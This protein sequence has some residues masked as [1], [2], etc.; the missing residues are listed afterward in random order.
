MAKKFFVIDDVLDTIVT[1]SAEMAIELSNMRDEIGQPLVVSYGFL[2]KTAHLLDSGLLFVAVDPVSQYAD[3]GVVKKVVDM[4]A[5][6]RWTHCPSARI[7][8]APAP[9]LLPQRISTQTVIL[10]RRNCFVRPKSHQIA[11]FG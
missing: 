11:R 2:P 3:R 4:L 6:R 9:G 8:D 1:C 10:E 5:M 7:G